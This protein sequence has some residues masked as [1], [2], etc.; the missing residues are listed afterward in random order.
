VNASFQ[1]VAD[2]YVTSDSPAQNFGTDTTMHVSDVDRSLLR[3]NLSS[4]PTGATVTDADL[5]LCYSSVLTLAAGRTHEMN[6]VDESWTE[7][8]VNW[9][10]QPGG[11]SGSAISWTVPL[12]TGCFQVDVTDPVGEWV[13]DGNN[14]GWRITDEDESSAPHVEYAT[15]QNGVVGLRPTLNVTYTL[16]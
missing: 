14:F 13:S 2:S 16:P 3:F 6:R 12:V 7:P 11:N 5:V 4:I 1:A 8:G 15:R 10:N 9:N